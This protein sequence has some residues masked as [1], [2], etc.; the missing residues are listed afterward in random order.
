MMSNNFFSGFLFSKSSQTSSKSMLF[1]FIFNLNPVGE[2]L[3]RM[4]LGLIPI[5]SLRKYGHSSCDAPRLN[6]DSC[7]NV[8]TFVKR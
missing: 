8:L 1:V 4:G 5:M 7:N 6:V 3:D 2:P